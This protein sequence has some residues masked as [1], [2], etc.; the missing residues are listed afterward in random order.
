MPGVPQVAP[1]HEATTPEPVELAASASLE[2]PPAAIQNTSEMHDSEVN[3]PAGGSD[4]AGW[5]QPAAGTTGDGAVVGTADGRADV[6]VVVGAVVVGATEVAVTWRTSMV[7][8][9]AQA[10]IVRAISAARAEAIRLAGRRPGV[11]APPSRSD[12]RTPRTDR[13]G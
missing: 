11:T 6:V 13:Q 12:P 7:A 2:P 3:P 8:V 4:V 5:D 9:D 10:E 1:S